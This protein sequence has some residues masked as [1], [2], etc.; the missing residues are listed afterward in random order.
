MLL[1]H[2]IFDYSFL[3]MAGVV[4]NRVFPFVDVPIDGR[5]RRQLDL[6]LDGLVRL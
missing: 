1:T 5:V 4:F 6:L 3:V 2:F